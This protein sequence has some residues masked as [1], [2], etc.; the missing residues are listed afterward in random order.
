MEAS[1][2][3]KGRRSFTALSTVSSLSF[4]ILSLVSDELLLL[5]TE[6]GRE[7]DGNVRSLSSSVSKGKRET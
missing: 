2:V 1:C 6:T 7:E 5:K 3:S 4:L